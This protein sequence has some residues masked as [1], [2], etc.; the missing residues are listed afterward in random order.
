MGTVLNYDVVT[1]QSNGMTNPLSPVGSPGYYLRHVNNVIGLEIDY[2]VSTCPPSQFSFSIDLEINTREWDEINQTF[3]NNT[4]L[5][6]LNV[7]YDATVG[8]TN[9]DEHSFVFENAYWVEA[10]ILNMSS[11]TNKNFVKLYNAITIERYQD[12]DA[13]F[14]PSF[15]S[16]Q[17]LALSDQI[18]VSW[19]AVDGAEEYE[20][21]WQYIDD[22]DVDATPKT[23]GDLYIEFKNNASRVILTNTYYDFSSVFD[24]GYVVCRV[25][26]VGKTGAN[27]EHRVNGVWS[28]NGSNYLN[29][30]VLTAEAFPVPFTSIQV[31]EPNLNWQYSATYAENG[32]RKEVIAYFD[33]SLRQRQ[34]VTRLNTEQDAAV[35]ETFY[36]HNGRPAVTAI[37]A[38][39]FENKL[40]FYEGFNLSST[41]GE[42]YTRSD[43]DM[44]ANCTR[45]I[46]T[47]DNTSGASKYYSSNN[48]L[49]SNLGYE[50]IPHALGY[51]FAVTEY[52]PDNTGRVRRQG[53]V[54]IDHQLG[55]GHETKY[56]YATPEQVELDR[57]FGNNVG[58]YKH[59]QKNMVVDPNGQV[60]VS[61]LD[62]SG[63]VI[64]TALAGES[65]D[66]LDALP[67]AL[68]STTLTV[69]LNSDE[70]GSR[71]DEFTINKQIIVENQDVAH[72]LSY[73]I[74]IPTFT[75]EHT[76]GLCYDCVYELEISVTDECMNEVL[77]GDPN[78]VG[79]QPIK[80]LIGKIGQDFDVNCDGSLSYSFDTD[81]DLNN[82][83]I[84]IT[85]STGTY[86]ISKRLKIS[87]DAI[88]Y[89]K[90]QYLANKDDLLSEQD[91]IDQ[92]LAEV[93][94]DDCELDCEVCSELYSTAQNKTDFVNA[95]LQELVN[96]G[97][98]PDAED[99]AAIEDLF[100][101]IKAD[102]DE[103]CS[104]DFTS[105]QV[106][107]E[108]LK[109]DMRPG[110]QYAQYE[111]DA[112]GNFVGHGM[113]DEAEVSTVGFTYQYYVMNGSN[114]M[115]DYSNGGNVDPWIMVAGEKTKP[116]FMTPQEYVENFD[117]KWIDALVKLHPE[118]CEYEFCMNETESDEYDRDMM[119][120]KTYAEAY[121]RGF[122]NP[123]GMSG[124]YVPNVT[125]N[126]LDPFFA[127]NGTGNGVSG[128]LET[129]L[130]AFKNPDPE[131]I[132]CRNISAWE[133]AMA[134]YICGMENGTCS[135]ILTC[136]SGSDWSPSG[137]CEPYLDRIWIMFRSIY[138]MEKKRLIETTFGCNPSIPSGYQKRYPSVVDEDNR[139]S[140]VKSM[141]V[142]QT[143]TEIDDYC[144]STCEANVESWL[145]KLEKCTL[146]PSEKD[147]LAL[148]FVAVCTA[149]CDTDRPFGSIDLAT[150]QSV[151]VLGITAT[152]FEDIFD[153]VIPPTDTRRQAGVCDV[154][155]I[156]FP[157]SYDHDYLAWKKPDIEGCNPETL[158]LDDCILNETNEDLKKSMIAQYGP[159]SSCNSCVDCYE[160]YETLVEINTY[161]GVDIQTIPNYQVIL[162]QQLNKRLKFNLTYWEY[163]DFMQQCAS[164]N[165]N[166]KDSFTIELYLQYY[167][168]YAFNDVLNVPYQLK[169]NN[170]NPTRQKNL[171]LDWYKGYIEQIE[172]A[173][174]QDN[175][176]IQTGM[177]DLDDCV[178]NKLIGLKESYNSAPTPKPPFS[179]WVNNILNCEMPGFDFEDIES[180]CRKAY[181]AD[182]ANNVIPPASTYAWS[183]AQ[184]KAIEYFY[185]GT[186]AP[187][188]PS[189]FDC[190]NPD[191]IITNL[192]AITILTTPLNKED[193]SI[194]SQFLQDYETNVD[195]NI[196]SNLQAYCNL[197]SI[198][199]C[200]TCDK[201]L[202]EDFM[203]QFY[204]AY[205]DPNYPNINIPVEMFL[206]LYIDCFCSNLDGSGCSGDCREV[207]TAAL[208]FLE[209]LNEI[210]TTPGSWGS[211]PNRL[212]TSNW[213]L[214]PDIPTYYN[215]DWYDG[216][217]LSTLKFQNL[218]LSKF[219]ISS[220]IS[221]NC[222][223]FTNFELYYATAPYYNGNYYFDFGSVVDFTSIEPLQNGVG[224]YFPNKFKVYA[225]QDDGMSNLF[226]VEF[227][228]T[229]YTS[230]PA[231]EKISRPCIKLCNKPYY[232]EFEID[233]DPCRNFKDQVATYNA[234]RAYKKYIE[235]LEDDFEK[236]YVE[237]CR[238]GFSSE[239][240]TRTYDLN[241]YHY[242]LYYYDLSNNL[243]QTVP[244]AGVD[245]IT[246]QA[247]FNQIEAA[248]SG[249]ASPIYNNHQLITTYSQNSLNQ[250]VQ[251]NTP[252]G[253]ESNFWYDNL[254][255]LV[256]SQNQKQ[257]DIP[258]HNAMAP[259]QFSYTVFDEQ[260]RISE[261]GQIANWNAM[262]WQIAFDENDLA[263]FIANAN[264]REQVTHSYYDN[265]LFAI[266]YK[267]F[268]A[269]NLRSRVV[270]M[271]YEDA[272]DN[273]D[274]TYNYGTHYSYDIHGNVKQLVQEYTALASINQEFRLLEYDYE[275]IS[276][277]VNTFTYQKDQED[278]FI[279]KYEYDDDN[280]LVAAYTSS[281]G[282]HWDKD[283]SYEYFRH[284]PLMRQEIGDLRVQ[285]IDYAYT[286]QG[287]LKGVNSNTL[288][289]D[290]DI[291][292]DG[293]SGS[294]NEYVGKDVFG[295][296]LGYYEGDFYEIGSIL[297]S[298][299]AFS[300]TSSSDFGSASPDLFNGNI[301]H[302][303][304]A[305]QPFMG[306]N[307]EPMGMAYT[308]D[309]LN[310]I[311]SATAWDDINVTTNHWRQPSSGP[312]Q[313]YACNYT[314][315]ANG[316]IMTLSRNGT[317][318]VNTQMDNF[319]YHYFPG[320]NKLEYVSDMVNSS[321]YTNDIDDQLPGNYLYDEIGNLISDQAEGIDNIEWTVYGKIKSIDKNNTAPILADLEFEY[322][323]DGNR[324]M[325]RVI[326][327]NAMGT[328][329]SVEETYYIRDASGNVIS[330]YSLAN[331]DLVWK[332]A[333]MYGSSRVGMFKPEKL[334]CSNGVPVS[335]GIPADEA[336]DIRGLKMYE[337]SNHLG[338][339]LAV[340]SD[341]KMLTCPNLLPIY[342]AELLSANDYYPFGMQMDGRS[343]TL[344]GEGYRFGFNGKEQD[345]EG[346]G[347]GQ[348]TYDYG[349]RIYNPAIGKFLSVDPL[350]QSYPWYT[351]YQFA[352]NQPI[353]A[354]DL[355]GLESSDDKNPTIV[356]FGPENPNGFSS[357][358]KNQL[359]CLLKLLEAS[360]VFQSIIN[361]TENVENIYLYDK[362]TRA[363]LTETQ[364]NT[365]SSVVSGQNGYIG[366]PQHSV[367]DDPRTLTTLVYEVTNVGNMPKYDKLD[368]KAKEGSLTK[369][370]Y[371]S[372][373]FQAEALAVFNVLEFQHENPEADDGSY[374]GIKHIFKLY[375]EGGEYE[376]HIVDRK[377][378]LNLIASFIETQNPEIK[379]IYE[380]NYDNITKGNE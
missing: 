61:Y 161:Y 247:D 188:V 126:E 99:Q 98:T 80:R 164:L 157:M 211:V 361:S 207:D 231:Q 321:N 104:S 111:Y 295:F 179:D 336:K 240:F 326:T 82:Q 204:G 32:L 170:T 46:N 371:V 184:K 250:I 340:V 2:D 33:G 165:S 52:T 357:D 5:K 89:Y 62:L 160:F 11:T 60:S 253:G 187:M 299:L 17:Y 69:T 325:K 191:P 309:Q 353:H 302:M 88:E 243:V 166:I 155:L 339:V 31:H 310:R 213:Y 78:T 186:N 93:N 246:A 189:C 29:T 221:D 169:E 230:A 162:E 85:L 172:W 173:S 307:G 322:T 304:T 66:N 94:Y 19:N 360:Q 268:S 13:N 57:L 152:S 380:S 272:Y 316:N 354:I 343:A 177:Q 180:L 50:Y 101:Q 345:K 278:Q 259:P 348:S 301:K 182:A 293:Q 206:D 298:D 59:Y 255:R 334:I 349:F 135:D 314:Y 297:S 229:L 92:Y 219:F 90:A 212:L 56:Y 273:D 286:I 233:E 123:L 364:K 329:V 261:V 15:N 265:D 120:T 232:Q 141:A 95:K 142:S 79:N 154:N 110:G 125:I 378:C 58:N 36:D 68:N 53:G 28:N 163:I 214:Q 366:L 344:T 14:T 195:P 238:T 225:L 367:N 150:G 18:R 363:N 148:G 274:Y 147:D 139:I 115:T 373:Q 127:S 102:C 140:D 337:L 121:S 370:E 351:P 178:C 355:D 136:L 346:M 74:D 42:A 103:L 270:S 97:V 174:T 358:E 352:S 319:I 64:A 144:Q 328:I 202:L 218:D 308:Y 320:T 175:M 122:L 306:T 4:Y 242:T 275:L 96:S 83:D 55:T 210:V 289:S 47:M 105:C 324:A 282:V 327:K 374:E 143:Q 377:G 287:W 151:S 77:D 237:H 372:G 109:A 201:E 291:G 226:P 224:C 333:M 249:I 84:I 158:E 51:A 87:Q 45:S 41:S 266:S 271:T 215:S 369:E 350:T 375:K 280:R 251:Q 257:H 112:N 315:D 7:D 368:E 6:T 245:F 362:G 223:H 208:Y 311:K 134:T 330:T 71:L 205:P 113:L 285:G 24:Q 288:K 167:E 91:F 292:R 176:Q 149:G 118:Y 16:W 283:A 269:D 117:E 260:G 81:A 332:E 276:G 312:L 235:D 75:D 119:E 21:E 267:N 331:N 20:L 222:T 227:V 159:D 72:T 220:Y 198:S 116:I 239:N 108:Q 54:G 323:P 12:I 3:N 131:D 203:E 25:R 30:F 281:N 217:C 183:S 8:Q 156:N 114:Y 153:H 365:P 107:L 338:N 43:F 34:T 27:F 305:L 190:T 197:N 106:F 23:A 146:T 63:R 171:P 209:V 263:N 252:D 49:A 241:E 145:F 248:R 44:S 22:Y 264:T 168:G 132:N 303:I 356:V 258:N 379:A 48:P 194:F 234:K 37:P 300:Q 73:N 86:M 199:N 10:K 124:S 236:R 137:I 279:H 216:S 341:R 376:G 38:P 76:I 317:T 35:A 200:S 181:L 313:D 1:Y 39:A 262:S 256:I 67:T 129:A 26:A 130:V 296:S 244:P 196:I 277:N 133:A 9:L 228:M 318:A 284:G 342:D 290:R 138:L 100:D 128:S 185:T 192:G 335:S 294:I 70:L 347:G 359:E 40:R 254:G 193:C 65:P